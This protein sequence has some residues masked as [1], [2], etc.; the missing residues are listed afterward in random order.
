MKR[1]QG[2]P[3]PSPAQRRERLGVTTR[4]EWAKREFGLRVVY[5]QPR[6]DDAGH[7]PPAP[8]AMRT[9]LVVA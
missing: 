9:G 4:E 3:P 5:L 1:G 7:P 2:L 8:S 6:D